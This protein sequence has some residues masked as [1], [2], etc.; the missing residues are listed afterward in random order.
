MSYEATS[1]EEFRRRVFSTGDFNSA[2]L[3]LVPYTNFDEVKPEQVKSIEV[4]YKSV[5]SDDLL[6]DLSY[7]YN[8]YNDFITSVVVITAEEYT[9]NAARNNIE[10]DQ[11]S[12]TTDGTLNGTP[13]Y[14][15]LLNSSAHTISGNGIDGNTSSLYSNAPGT[16]TAQGAVLG[17]TYN[18]PKGYTLS[19]NYNWNT[20]GDVPEGFIAEFNTPEHKMN[21]SFGNRKLTQN[22]GFNV[23]WRWQAAFDWQSSF[24]NYTLY[25]VPAYNT[26]DA[27]VSYKVPNIKSTIKLGGSNILNSKYIQSGGGPNISG[28]YY[29]SITYDELF[30]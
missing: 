14:A 19:G 25:P 10:D 6:V 24:T 26:M 16:V 1:V 22:L 23:T 2:V 5:I 9:T 11:F 15:T 28:L 17:L 21:F 30:R 29:I 7:Y 13:N 4:G 20:L 18:L 27:Q 3:A 12:Y 8:T